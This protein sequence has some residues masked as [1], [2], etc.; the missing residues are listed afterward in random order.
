MPAAVG[1]VTVV[2]WLIVAPAPMLPVA[3][4]VPTLLAE[5]PE[6]AFELVMRTCEFD[7][8]ATPVP[9]FL[10]CQLTL[11]EPPAATELDPNVTFNGCT[12]TVVATVT[13]NA[14]DTAK[15]LL[16]LLCERLLLLSAITQ[17]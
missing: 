8:P 16:V 13:V 10:I 6:L 3:C 14:E 1:T 4:A 11:I 5:L 17:T 2:L 15:S 12:S 9:L 7:V